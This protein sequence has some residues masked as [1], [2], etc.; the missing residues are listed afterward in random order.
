MVTSPRGLRSNEPRQIGEYRILS[1]LGKGGQ[2]TVYL[3]L[4]PDGRRVAIKALLPQWASDPKTCRRFLREAEVAAKVAAFC[5][6]KI[7]GTGIF[8]GR[9]YIVSEY[10]P[11]PSLDEKVKTE[12]PISGSGLERLAVSTLTALA[13]I[14]AHG[15]VHRDF[16][17]GNVILGPEGPVVIDFGIARALDSSMSTTWLL[18]TP[19]YL[20]PEQLTEEPVTA[21]CDVFSWGSTMTFAA[22]GRLPFNGATVPAIM[23]AILHADPDLSGV[24]NPLREL[25]AAAL[26]KTPAARPSA[27]ELLRV[28]TERHALP[29]YPIPGPPPG[30]PPHPANGTATRPAFG[31]LT[32]AAPGAG[33]PG[34]P[35]SWPPPPPAPPPHLAAAHTSQ[36][37]SG[38]RQAD[39]AGAPVQA[40]PAGLGTAVALPTPREHPAT[41]AVRPAAEPDAPAPEAETTTAPGGRGSHRKPWRPR[42]CVL[43]TSATVLTLTAATILVPT[44][45]R[46]GD[47][48]SGATTAAANIRQ[49]AARAPAAPPGEVSSRGDLDLGMFPKLDIE[50]RFTAPENVQQYVSHQPEEREMVP[51]IAT[52][53]GVFTASGPTPYFTMLSGPGGLSGATSLSMVTLGEFTGK[54]ETQDTVYVGWV[55]DGNNYISAWYNNARKVSGLSVRLDGRLL[56]L[57]RTIY[58]ELKK[59]D[60]LALV[61]K[62]GM[63]TSYAETHGMWHRLQETT[64]DSLLD[65]PVNRRDYRYGF[66]LRA[67]SGTITL[68]GAVGRSA[69]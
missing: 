44:W 61:H 6:A 52:D 1:L 60:R 30:P 46:G 21:A 38:P 40:L 43:I 17:P 10:V 67:E 2:G 18:G 51:S 11:G 9:P 53:N 59:G 22:T 32:G 14:H 64:I 25:V 13:S 16:K 26:A 50:D 33:A 20:A 47:G 7:V 69:P 68:T 63:I 58:V 23:H 66:G 48:E 49:E 12:G 35:S 36:R 57:P 34:G 27:A 4:A 37:A 56:K 65:S 8:A 62:D 45:L 31:M 55:K 54:G 15:V 3:G 29:A 41:D 42:R 28:L 24:P 19:A 39:A 5:T